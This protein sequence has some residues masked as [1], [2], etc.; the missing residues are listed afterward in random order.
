M[1]SADCVRRRKGLFL[2]LLLVILG[3]WHA[4]G[5][6]CS[7]PPI[8]TCGCTV[9]LTK[10]TV[11]FTGLLGLTV[12]V[13]DGGGNIFSGLLLLP[14]ST[15]TVQSSAGAGNPFVGN[16]V[17]IRTTLVVLANINTSCTN[18]VKIGTSFGNFVVTGGESVGGAPICCL[19][20]ESTPPNFTSCP[21]NVDVAADATA[22]G[23]TVTWTAP[24]VT[25][26]CAVA[27]VIPD[28]NSGDF[29]PVGTTVVK[30]TATDNY[31][32]TA[33]CSFNV[34]VRDQ[35][36][37]VFAGCP[38][39]FVVPVNPTT[40]NAVVNWTAPTAT[41]ACDGAITPTSPNTPGTTFGLGAHTI[42][43][44]AED[45]E[46]NESTCSFTVTV[47]DTTPPVFAGCPTGFSVP[48]NPTTCN[49]IVNW[50]P[51]TATDNCGGSITPTSPDAPGATFGLGPHTITYTAN[52]G[53]GN[54]S[55]CSFVVTVTDNTA[56]VIAGCPA[57]FSVPVNPT[58]CSA[59]VNWTTPTATDNCAGSVTP[60]SPDAPGTTFG[61]GPH[62]ITYTA[63][64]GNGNQST[65]SFT[66][67]VTD[68]T[69]PVF[70]GCPTDFSVSVNP[71]TC[72]AIVNWT[73]PTATDNCA[74]SIT[75]TSP[76]APGATFGLGPH[77][78]TYTA[79]DGR[80]NQSTC[81]FVVTVTDNTAPV[82]AGC[83]ANF[84]VPVNP[85]T[86]TAVVNWTAPTAT[87]NCVGAI[88]P[89]SPD[90]P[91]ATF[92]LGVHTITYTANDGRG[93]QSTC[94]FV[95]TVTDNTA[96]VLA[97]CPTD[98]SVP[99]N[100]TTC[101]AVVT[102]TA[103]TATDN[104]AGSIIPI[105]PNAPGATFGLGPH[106][107]TYTANDGHGN[108]STCSFVV[109]VTDNT[110]PVFAGC[111][112]DFSVS[113]NPTTCNAVVNWIAPTVTDNCAGP[114]TPTSPDAPGATFG[115]GPHII[116]YTANDG[117]G[118]Q[119]TCS[120]TV[121]VTDNTAPVFAGCPANFAVPVDP[122]SCT[123]IVN[124]TAPT[125]MDNCAGAIT[126]TSPD[127]PGATF[128]LGPH[129]ITYTAND[130]H[131][132]QSIC[133]FVVTVTDNTAPV[134]AGC[135]ADFSVPVNPTTCNAVVNWTAPTATDNCA[136]SIT[137][138]SPDAPGATFGLGPHTIT[139]TASDGNGNQSTCSFV[140]T[141]TDNTAPVFAGC[142]TDF[143]VSV[144][145][146][147]CNAVVN[148]TAPTATDNCAGAI[149]PTSPDAPRATF[150]LGAHTITYTANDGRGNQSTCSFVV[151]VTDNTAPVFAG[152]PADFSVPVNPATCNAVVNWTA[153]T[154]TDN[155]AGTIIPTS[156]DAPGA[157]F[158]LGAHTIT[159][160]AND[161]KGNQSTCSFIVTVT[162]NTPPVFAGCPADFSVPVNPTT[163]NA[164]VNWTPP[165]ATDNC[166]GSI[167]P[168][169]PDSPGA[170][171]TLGVH[172][173]TYTAN[174]GKGNQS[175]CSFV[176]T[177]TDN[178]APV[179]AGCPADFSV[180]VNPTTCDA[181]VNWTP[182]TATDNCAGAL[183]PTS[184]DAPGATF[185]LGPH[186]ITYT[187]N[188][189]NGNQSTCSFIV[190]VTDNTAPVFA[191][192]PADFSVPV[193]STTCDAVVNWT[194]PT[195]TDNCAGSLTPTSPD[196]PGAT[197]GLGP[198]TI[199]YTVNDGHGNQ[200]TCSFIVTV[201]D[202]TPPVFAGCPANFSVAVGPTACTAIVN[203][204]P[205]TATD[206]CAGALIPT[207]PDAPGSTFALGAHTIIYTANDGHGNQSTCS[208][209]V[210]VTDNTP[211]V[212][213][214]CPA[215]FSVPV[216]PTTCNAVVNWTPPTATDNC[217][218]ITPTS[219]DAPGATFG[220]GAHTITYTANDGHGNLSTC[221]FVVTVT[222][223][224]PPV[225]AG[226]P[227]DFSVPVNS[228]SCDAVVHWTPP[229]A[230][231]NCAGSLIPTSPDA[232]GATF[233]LGAH[234]I[235]YTADDGHG[236]Q[237]T[238]SF[239]VTVTD[240]T[241]PVFSGC[242]TDF[243][244][245]VNPTTC[246]VVVNWTPPTATDNCAGSLIPTSPNAP[247]ATFALGAHIITYTAN[248]G[249]GNQSTCSFTVTV[250]DAT[251]PVF[252]N[253]PANISVPTDPTS[254]TA[255]VSWAPLIVTDNC[256][257]VPVVTSNFHSGDVFTLGVHTVTYEATDAAGNKETCSFT[258]TVEDDI[259]PVFAGCPSN[260]VVAAGTTSCDLAALWVAPTASDNCT[261]TPV[262]SSNFDPGDLFPIGVTTVTYTAE[263]G[264]GNTTTCSFTVTVT[265]NTAP[266]L[267]GCPADIL[268]T[269]GA[270]CQA[271]AN[272]NPPVATDNCSVTVTSNHHPGEA[273]PAGTTPVIYTATDAAGN[274][275]TCSFNVI[276][277]DAL[278]PVF[279]TCPANIRV[280]AGTACGANVTWNAPTAT[281]NCSATL[282]LT[283]N[284]AAGDFFAVGTTTVTYTVADLA[285]NSATCSFTVTVEDTTPP[286]FQN[287]PA[288]ISVA[289]DNSCGAIVHWTPPTAT[290]NC[291][292]A[293]LVS[294]HQPG[295]R[296]DTGTTEVVYTATDNYGNASV[297][298]FNVTVRNE[299][300][301][302]FTGC[303]SDVHA[304]AGESGQV[305][306]TWEPP[307]AATR[308]G[309]LS[310]TGS[311]EPGEVFSVGT[312]PVV[313]TAQNDAGN[314]ITCSFNV[315]VDY[316]DLEIEV[317][318]VVTPD[319]D[320]KNDEWIVVNIEK[321][322]RNK[323]LVLDRWGSVIYQ[324]SG[325]N[326]ST[327]VW[328][329]VNSNGV[330]VPTGTYYYVIEV[331]FREKHLK[332]SGF[333]ELLR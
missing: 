128:G 89:T 330:Q 78:I 312:T 238:C 184:P 20:M 144:N 125:A 255:A 168:T 294:S 265:D 297:C 313:Y 276:A 244:V 219:P 13:Q 231:D 291:G 106:T 18:Q 163:C 117:N 5:Q 258:V 118:N 246:D 121:T 134:L 209:I 249:H 39:N 64:D 236:N 69:A 52:D 260:I 303:P 90:A 233:A 315:I 203:W 195:A 284:H 188:D 22:C 158:A 333:I 51:P 104:C 96:P 307:T 24:T 151:T 8:T 120:F 77:T 323:V 187:A 319:G 26:N 182:P 309:E 76:D 321:F 19:N 207:S 310:L 172:T 205:P 193:N 46:G 116:T 268:V 298:R 165:T 83:P 274:V 296:F 43:Y 179:I 237:S 141:V 97:G 287:C 87:D 217:G 146:T 327:M 72:N 331:D 224:T 68:N 50:T 49:A 259:N 198:H 108:Q 178:T 290:D 232:P 91:G 150:A 105:S 38:A 60:T 62:I 12:D 234:T 133:S 67:T 42:T 251:K 273:F 21:P 27:S 208:F 79:N 295:E 15:F 252:T 132:N 166:A 94:S 130:G 3:Q 328:S 196:V 41:D 169:S 82:F 11:Q 261:A 88:V 225:F 332:K 213:A 190:T 149:I 326:N 37:P 318:K 56:P 299:E 127:A 266:V 112:T 153:P 262:V 139:Y 243:S 109:T 183:I 164:I 119:S 73:A 47:T 155:C 93:N 306:V 57:D 257:A 286:A 111:P 102:W 199:T 292:V 122:T 317:T 70:A 282:S 85:T 99:V 308:C 32:N 135:P 277:S 30:Y 107:I 201:T 230:T 171:F 14:G 311:H 264:A 212:L 29:F 177:V 100:P 136:G 95:V 147:T 324:A 140:V 280:S 272:W 61:L 222:D 152:C 200:S 113:V 289:S 129:T 25:D 98:F 216:N 161:G 81:S 80:G 180:S 65:C 221:S 123:A 250:V 48:V 263:D 36:A 110:A 220:L 194:P 202:N 226:C 300:V 204:T 316:E 162:D 185:G 2:G 84:S 103:P 247:G 293:S 270:A 271:V 227:T 101:N 325:Y 281:D 269:T 279:N 126:P 6:S 63:S 176:V 74:G 215:D 214:G 9:G 322:A 157:T 167:I 302:S 34:R 7:C 223:N 16:Q 210:T 137:P 31:G 35:T 241:P 329:G 248:D 1:L 288:Q 189:G 229:T 40:C 206:N 304:K 131:G 254:C 256:D 124:W 10:M 138:T 267:T 71:T 192:C 191:G 17:T 114:I 58:T 145:P 92:G 154:A 305:A 45:D 235:T 275:T 53:R 4:Y 86:C 156:P 181:V 148:W 278:A 242:P 142:P 186:T 59:V 174:D 285:G 170:T 245:P 160:T 55:T 159:Y 173:I 211:P 115:L 228:T 283:A 218:V 28:H 66:V 33:N 253:C 320:G 239:V 75:P 197:F 240:N 314:T 175:T 143:S 44:T 23:K 301:P 54:Q